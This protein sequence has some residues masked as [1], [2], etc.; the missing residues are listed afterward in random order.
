MAT[1]RR[2][3]LVGL[4][5]VSACLYCAHFL[6]PSVPL[7]ISYIVGL[8]AA[9][10]IVLAFG[11]TRLDRWLNAPPLLS[12][13]EYRTAFTSCIPLSCSHWSIHFTA[14]WAR[15][16]FWL[17]SS[18]FRYSQRGFP[19]DSSSARPCGSDTVVTQRRRGF[20]SPLPDRLSAVALA[21]V[22]APLKIATVIWRPPVAQSGHSGADEEGNLLIPGSGPLSAA[23]VVFLEHFRERT[24]IGFNSFWKLYPRLF[25]SC[26]RWLILP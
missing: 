4:A 19:G 8:G 7:Q 16:R 10:F 9:G 17:W 15:R 2:P 20:F 13:G 12:L 22:S 5:L 3:A 24:T 21:C 23:F 11:R 1:L 18:R 25:A 14:C 6:V 26:L